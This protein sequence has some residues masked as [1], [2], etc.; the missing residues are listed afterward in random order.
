M[1][2]R[3]SRNVVAR[4]REARARRELRE[5][6][7]G[8]EPESSEGR[9]AEA[10]GRR[11]FRGTAWGR[12]ER[13]GFL[14]GRAT[15]QVVLAEPDDV[16][17]SQGHQQVARYQ[18]ALQAADNLILSDID[19]SPVPLRRLAASATRAPV[20]PGIGFSREG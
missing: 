12:R 1:R 4:E 20:T 13:T 11:R 14:S 2:A 5:S 15:L 16:A 10:R 7:R 8:G 3:G 18:R 6:G 17:R 19:V 9:R